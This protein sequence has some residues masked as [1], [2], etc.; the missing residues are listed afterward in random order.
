MYKRNLKGVLELPGAQR[1]LERG[2]RVNLLY[3]GNLKGVLELP[4][5][6]RKL[7]R[8]TGVTY[9]FLGAALTGCTHD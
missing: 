4:G 7:E 8:G 5:V 3:K 1:E 6:Q 2:N 9:F